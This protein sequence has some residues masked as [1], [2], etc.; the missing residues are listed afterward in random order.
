MNRERRLHGRS[1]LRLN[2]RLTLAAAAHS[3]DMVRHNYFSHVTPG[4]V[5]FVSRI[6]RYRY[7]T[8]SQPW[9]LGENIGAGTGRLSTPAAMVAGWMHSPG[10]R[11]IL[12]GRSYRVVGVG[13]ALGS[14]LPSRRG[15]TYTADFGETGK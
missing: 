9:A 8:W 12:L 15:A 7:A 10:H 5:G 3:R 11:A 2:P 4:G 6:L 1:S 13:L 14:P